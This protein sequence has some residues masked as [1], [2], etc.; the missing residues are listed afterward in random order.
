MAA[1]FSVN[2]LQVDF[3]YV[4]TMEHSGMVSML[5]TLKN[6]GLK[7]FLNATGSVYEAAVG[8]FFANTKVTAGTI[9]SFVA[10]RKLP[11]SKEMFAE[12]FGLPTE[13]M[14]VRYFEGNSDPSRQS[15]GYAV[16]ISVMLRNMVNADLGESIKLHPQKVLTGKSMATYINKNL[17]VTPGGESS[18]HTKDTT[19]NIE[20]AIPTG[21]EGISIAGGPEVHPETRTG[22]EHIAVGPGGP[23]RA[24]SK[25]DEQVGGNDH[26]N[27]RHEENSRSDTQTDQEDWVDKDEIIE[28]DENCNNFE[29]ETGTNAK[30]IVVRS[31]PEQ[32]AQQTITYIGKGIFA[33]IKIRE[34]NWATHFL[35]KIDPVVAKGK[36]MLEVVT[37]PNPVKEHCQ[38]VLKSA[39]EAVSNIM[40][41][42]DEWIHFRTMVKL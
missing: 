27:D 4:L 12:A 32:P 29:K 10:N 22:E 18:K 31:G 17:K 9:V 24:G 37:R 8:E 30:A 7:G 13:G 38:L 23:E 26:D 21:N 39:W 36:V 20:D 40:A 14:V 11:L 16:Q 34:I 42:F 15:H 25:Q 5:K 19:S 3:E 1:S 6:T 33:P 35:P 2:T 28:R 41:D